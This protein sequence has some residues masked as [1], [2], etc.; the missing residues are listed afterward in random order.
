MHIHQQQL[1]KEHSK[2]ECSETALVSNPAYTF[3][4]P[5]ESSRAISMSPSKYSKNLA[6]IHFYPEESSQAVSVSLSK[7]S[8]NP[9][10]VPFAPEGISQAVSISPIKNPSYIHLHGPRG[11]LSSRQF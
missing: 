1:T 2:E 3:L 6:Y 9:A 4:D 5:E 7:C 10:Y 8:R 11:K